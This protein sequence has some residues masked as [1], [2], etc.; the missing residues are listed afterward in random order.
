MG[1]G[2]STVIED[3]DVNPTVEE[4]RVEEHPRAR[5]HGRASVTVCRDF[6]KGSC[7]YGDRCRYSHENG[8][9]SAAGSGEKKLCRDFLKGNC[10]YGDRCKYS[11]DQGGTPGDRSHIPCRQFQKGHCVF[12]DRCRYGHDGEPGEAQG[13][14]AITIPMASVH[15]V[16]RQQ[17]SYEEAAEML[18]TAETDCMQRLEAL[19]SQRQDL[20]AEV[21]AM[22]PEERT[23]SLGVVWQYGGRKKLAAGVAR[24]HEF[25]ASDSRMVEEEYQRWKAAGSSKDPSSCR[26][27][28]NTEGG[29][30]LSL[31][32]HLLTQ[33]SVGKKGR[34]GLQRKQLPSKAQE[35]CQPFFSAVLTVVGDLCGK[36]EE[37]SGQLAGMDAEESELQQLQEQEK[38]CIEALRPSIGT[39]VELSIFCGANAMMEKLEAVLG[40]RHAASLGV[41]AGGR[42]MRVEAVCKAVKEAFQ[43]RAYG[44]GLQEGESA[45]SHLR[46]LVF[47]GRKFYE[48]NMLELREAMVKFRGESLEK[49]RRHAF[50]AAGTLLHE[51]SSDHAFQRDLRGR[52]GKLFE[53]GLNEALRN[54]LDFVTVKSILVAAR[55]MQLGDFSAPVSLWLK[56]RLS[57]SLRSQQPVQTVVELVQSA[58]DFPGLDGVAIVKP[59]VPQIVDKCQR[60]ILSQQ[61][62][63]ANVN[64]VGLFA[65]ILGSAF[66]QALFESLKPS[67]EKHRAMLTEWLVAYTEHTGA[68]LPPYCMNANQKEA[69]DLLRQAIEAG[70]VEQLKRAAIEAK[71]VPDLK[72]H[73][74]LCQEFIRAL[75]ILKEQ[76]HMPP[77]WDLEDLLGTE[78]MFRKKPVNAERALQLFQV[79]MTSTHQKRWTRDRATRGDGKKIADAFEVARVTEVQNQ[80]SWENYHRRREEI[81]RE[82]NPPDREPYAP[83][84]PDQWQEWSGRVMTDDIGNEIASAC[85]LS[86]LDPRCNEFLFFHGVK[87][88]VADLIAENHFDI[89]FASKDGMFGAGLY[90]AEASS[91]SDEYCQPNEANEFPIIIVRVI[92]GRPNYVDAPKP[93]DD[94]GRRQL[95]HSCMSGTYHSVI[96]DR[97]KVSNTYREMA[98]RY[99]GRNWDLCFARGTL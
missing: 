74:E 80:A 24:W 91:K 95:E 45:W 72:S 65:K 27:E 92:L 31:D 49:K 93:F 96:G 6:A 23:K 62:S 97:I 75:D 21:Q 68:E 38:K 18:Q 53:E 67:Y 48:K 10:K 66:D 14:D 60:A 5:E 54:N 36:L 7:K 46:P 71:T 39:F 90:F 51:Y 86:P 34:R 33:M 29:M 15:V 19:E 26:V 57:S 94:P 78:K 59:L 28:I 20:S 3:D 4:N 85:R 2:G 99:G 44:K 64:Q 13:S 25:A 50:M 63:A 22:E 82:C 43:I 16:K 8:A 58:K 87:P 35:R 56:Q 52:L 61:L 1:A 30:R 89:S 73:E 37:V 98:A 76:A 11:H 12:G 40:E 42:E 77:G 55:N 88:Q 47:G 69:F 83:L 9:S 84:S 81:V 17:L 32:F 79:L 41:A 70:D